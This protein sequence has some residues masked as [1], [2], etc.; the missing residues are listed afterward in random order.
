VKIFLA[1]CISLL[2][3]NSVYAELSRKDLV[4]YTLDFYLDET[5]NLGKANSER[6]KHPEKKAI[7]REII[8][9][10]DYPL[11]SQKLMQS[12]NKQK[13]VNKA[14]SI[15]EAKAKKAIRKKSEAEK[16]E[17]LSQSRENKKEYG[18]KLSFSKASDK[19]KEKDTFVSR[20]DDLKK[21]TK[22]TEPTVAIEEKPN[23]IKGIFKNTHPYIAAIGQFDD[24]I[25][26]T[27]GDT[28]YDYVTKLYPGFE[29][30]SKIS[31]KRFDA[32]LNTG[33][34]V[35]R[36]AKNSQHDTASPFAKGFLKYNFGNLGFITSASSR[37]FR[38]TPS[39]LADEEI[40]EFIDSWQ[41][42]MSQDFKINFNRFDVDF[43]YNKSLSGYEEEEFKSSNRTKDV[44]ALRN[45]IKISPKTRL[46]AEYAHGWVNYDK[47]T[48]K[49]F[50]YDRPVVGVNGKIF[51]KLEGTI[52]VGYNFNRRKTLKD[53][54]GSLFS[55]FLTYKASPRLYYHLNAVNGLGDLNLISEGITKYKGASIGISY[56]PPFLKKLRVNSRVGYWQRG[57]DY[58]TKD[59]YWEVSFRPEYKLKDWLMFGI[60]YTFQNRNSKLQEND[61]RNNRIEISMFSEF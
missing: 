28:T 40:K 51:R 27:K 4:S 53:L 5:K 9:S 45:S 59:N 7:Q 50:D 52:K 25:Y 39:D 48:S 19:L 2:I 32:Y 24:N 57:S 58:Q 20:K 15:E 11:K 54:N 29:L 16:K 22:N 55:A 61:Y 31:P 56:L 49:N 43:Q 14:I 42:D 18:T 34:E 60:G 30:K 8:S 23:Y 26:H 35:L 1:F 44:I 46:F 41:Y 3:F 33:V 6:I 47:D 21:E 13:K 37:R 36:Y 10:P 38:G 17:A 12:K